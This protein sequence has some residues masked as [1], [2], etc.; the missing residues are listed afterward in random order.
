MPSIRP[1]TRRKFV[2]ALELVEYLL[3]GRTCHF[4]GGVVASA[5]PRI[6]LHHVNEDRTSACKAEGCEHAKVL[7]HASCHRAYHMR[8]GWKYGVLGKARSCRANA[9]LSKC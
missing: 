9:E 2:K 7:A 3:D 4:C 6:T 5:F 8:L 1:S